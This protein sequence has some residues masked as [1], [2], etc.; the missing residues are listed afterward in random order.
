MCTPSHDEASHVIIL[1]LS[2][3][4][5]T[6]I[7]SFQK[8]HAPLTP[9]DSRFFTRFFTH[10]FISPFPSPGLAFRIRAVSVQSNSFAMFI[11]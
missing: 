8:A 7:R 9:F 11:H 5:Q 2:T 3:Q 10:D 4:H 6:F 1:S